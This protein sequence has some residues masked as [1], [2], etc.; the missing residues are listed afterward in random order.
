MIKLTLAIILLGIHASPAAAQAVMKNGVV[1]ENGTKYC[2]YLEGPAKPNNMKHHTAPGLATVS[3][4]FRDKF[5]LSRNDSFLAIAMEAKVL[6]H[7]RKAYLTYFYS[8]RSYVSGEEV[9]IAYHP[10]RAEAFAKDLVKYKVFEDGVYNDKGARMLMKKWRTKYGVVDSKLLETGVVTGWVKMGTEA[11][12]DS[13]AKDIVVQDGKIY[14]RNTLLGYYKSG[15]PLDPRRKNSV[16][17]NTYYVQNIK[18]EH[19]IALTVPELRSVVF[20]RLM[21]TKEELQL[22]TAD[23]TTEKLVRAAAVVMLMRD[24]L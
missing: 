15:A 17:L 22:V 6:A 4:D 3:E 5:F 13:I 14:F 20:M 19:V 12:E 2:Y 10:L 8:I 18:G 9:H 7:F 23:K 1:W 16:G 21:K 11:T 24:D